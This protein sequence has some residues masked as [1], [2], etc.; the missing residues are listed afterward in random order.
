[1]A[2]KAA[3]VVKRTAPKPKRTALVDEPA[4]TSLKVRHLTGRCNA[5]FVLEPAQ[6]HSS[7]IFCPVC[8]R[9]DDPSTFV[10]A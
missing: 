9:H 10:A 3:P 2:K 8:Q 6:L 4:V 7:A 5:V 1:M